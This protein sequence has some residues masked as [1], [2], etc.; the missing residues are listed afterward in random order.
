M[1]V[2]STAVRGGGL[3]GQCNMYSRMFCNPMYCTALLC[4]M[5]Q[6]GLAPHTH[7]V[8]W[9]CGQQVWSLK[10]TPKAASG[11]VRALETLRGGLI[12]EANNC[13]EQS[14]VKFSFKDAKFV[15][16]YAGIKRPDSQQ[17]WSI[18][19]VYWHKD[20][21]AFLQRSVAFE[22]KANISLSV[23]HHTKRLGS[24]QLVNSGAHTSYISL[25]LIDRRC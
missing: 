4:M 24:D 18:K 14:D 10:Y 22:T 9:V 6:T 11:R 16:N 2:L 8:H 20:W 7:Y 19:F 12:E 5:Q 13:P 15:S 23:T 21:R 1:N 17:Q 3:V 25:Q